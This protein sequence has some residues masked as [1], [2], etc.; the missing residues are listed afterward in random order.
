M[1]IRGLQQEQEKILKKILKN[2]TDPE[3]F[4]QKSL[5]WTKFQMNFGQIFWKMF[6]N[7]FK[8]YLNIFLLKF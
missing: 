2:I 4:V 8:N 7:I 6:Q 3:N 1:Q 5:D